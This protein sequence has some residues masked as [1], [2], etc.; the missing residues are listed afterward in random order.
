DPDPD[1]AA[2]ERIRA[3]EVLKSAACA[4][5]ARIAAGF[6]A[7]QRARQA[8]AGIPANRRGLGVGAQLGLARRESPHRGRVHLGLA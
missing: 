6:D 8:A 2:V 3:L 4:A 1:A 5:Q 7:S